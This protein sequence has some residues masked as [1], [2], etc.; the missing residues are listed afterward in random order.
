MGAELQR[1]FDGLTE[2][3]ARMDQRR[4][5]LFCGFP[6]RRGQ[7]P[8]LNPVACSPQAWASAT[9]FQLMQSLLGL[10]FDPS[11]REI[12]L[13][14]PQLPRSIEWISG[15]NLRLGTARAGFTLARED[16]TVRLIETSED[17]AVRLNG[18]V[19]S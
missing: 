16:A 1:I 13:N 12:V 2:A 11:A 8:T 6:R 18:R 17:L 14:D 15:R 19:A 3:A 9:I 5:P 7:S 10:S 4:L